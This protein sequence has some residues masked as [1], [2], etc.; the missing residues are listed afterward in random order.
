MSEEVAIAKRKIMLLDTS[1]IIV[2]PKEF[3]AQNGW[4]P[5]RQVII[6][7]DGK[8]LILELEN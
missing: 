3:C 8:R 7:T 1:H 2:L 4:I 5:G 6:K